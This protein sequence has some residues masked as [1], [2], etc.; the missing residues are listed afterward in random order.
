MS[1]EVTYATLT[2]QD[3]VGARNNR[4]RNNLRKRGRHSEAARCDLCGGEQVLNAL[5]SML[6]RSALWNLQDG[7]KVVECAGRMNV[8]SFA[9]GRGLRGD[10][11]LPRPL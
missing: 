5:I 4:D 7:D 2:F 3:S 8:P 9:L 6:R 11:W 10:M 1:E